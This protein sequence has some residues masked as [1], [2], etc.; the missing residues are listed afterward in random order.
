MLKYKLLVAAWIS[1]IAIAG[2]LALAD[3]SL[4]AARK[5]NIVVIVGDDMGYAD[6]GF[7][8]CKDI[9]T[10]NLDALARAGVRCTNGYVSCPVCSP[11]RA[12]L[13]TGRYQQRFGHEFNPG[14]GRQDEVF[15]LPVSQVTLADR[16]KAAGYATGAVGKWHLG[17]APKFLPQKRRFD[18][19]YGFL[20]GAH[21][22]LNLKASMPQPI[23]R[24]TEPI[25]ETDYLTDA[26]AREAVNFVERHHES[27]FFLYLTFNAVHN[28]QHTTP[29]YIGRFASITDPKRQNYAAMMSALDDGIGRVLT[30]IHELK[31][32]DDTV[33]F[34]ISDNGGPTQA[35]TARNDPLRA[36]KA[37]VYEGGIRVPYV[38]RW[39]G[40]IKADSVYNEPV[41]SL[42]IVPTA[43]AAAGVAA[44]QSKEHSLDGVDLLPFVTG[45]DKQPPHGKLF[46]R[47]GQQHAVR[48]G[49]YK[50]VKTG[51]GGDELYDLSAD[52]SESKDLAAAKPEVVA[53]LN[54]DYAAWNEQLVEPGWWPPSRRQE[55]QKLQPRKQQ[56]KERRQPA[57][58]KQR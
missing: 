25:D 8:G 49:N 36:T 13:L 2:A 9:P 19:F 40:H 50:L 22:Y 45:K 17:F 31:L 46:W 54:K 56:Q 26:I 1:L 48:K 35:T 5:P 33:V 15:G 11:T 4:A 52:I 20:G 21:T 32:D 44:D 47:F 23:Y 51:A 7:Q 16:L 14:P 3:P 58:Q 37:T 43:L 18:E 55:Q 6:V 34:F 12:G 57:T 30:K 24:G 42:D 10:P 29:K 39:T 38:I 27:P 28:P 53:E 41:I